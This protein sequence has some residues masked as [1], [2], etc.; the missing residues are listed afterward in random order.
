MERNYGVKIKWENGET[1]T[2]FFSNSWERNE[3]LDGMDEIIESARIF[4]KNP[5]PSFI[6]DALGCLDTSLTEY[7][8]DIY[9]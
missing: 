3:Y 9:L 6:L 2:H 4:S 8:E 1:T 7:E 5:K